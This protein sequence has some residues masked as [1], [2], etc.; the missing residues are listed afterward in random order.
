MTRPLKSRHQQ[1]SSSCQVGLL[2]LNAT[3]VVAV[4]V[5]D[6]ADFDHDDDDDDDDNDGDDDDDDDDLDVDASIFTLSTLLCPPMG[7]IALIFLGPARP[8]TLSS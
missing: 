6:D 4:T 2:D 3:V 7:T 5:D 1:R 8:A